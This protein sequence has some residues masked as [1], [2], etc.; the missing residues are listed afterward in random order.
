MTGEGPLRGVKCFLLDMDGTFYLGD[1]ILEGSLA[2][3]RAIA[4]RGRD[5]LFLTNNSS[6]NAEYYQRKLEGMGLRIPI[7]K[8]LTSGQATAESLLRDYPNRR[9]YLL[10][11][12]YLEAELRG[13]GVAIDRNRP[14]L[15]VVGYDTTLTYAKL[16]ST[17]DLLRAGLPLV[18]THPDFNC[19]T[20]TGFAPDIGAILAF[21]R[22]STGRE[23]DLVVGKPNAG[24][25]DS[26]LR[27]AG[28]SAGEAAI[29][30]DRLYTDI[31]T[32][33]RHGILSILVMTGETTR[34]LLDE[35]EFRPDRVYGRLSEMIPDL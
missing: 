19:P 7:G 4:E 5:F 16:A 21:L 29:V 1:R 9:A 20:E 34:E 6:K 27:R 17:C 32:G 15:V 28:V 22:A 13:A 26:A 23:P 11:N 2:F 30:G 18:A 33:R 8:I 24:I 31:E 10:G 25:V 35:T 3:M 12:E 14:E